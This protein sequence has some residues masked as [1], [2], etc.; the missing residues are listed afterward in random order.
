ML[1]TCPPFVGLDKADAQMPVPDLAHAS[2][3]ATCL[4]DIRD[5]SCIAA[6]L[7]AAEDGRAFDFVSGNVWG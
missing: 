5:V 2:P 7:T 1:A 6:D 3:V 4:A